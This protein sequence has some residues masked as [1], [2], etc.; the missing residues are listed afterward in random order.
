MKMDN[1][2]ENININM[3]KLKIS[4]VTITKNEGKITYFIPEKMTGMKFKEFKRRNN[5]KIKDFIK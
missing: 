2:Y 4:N 1:I 3:D 5:Q